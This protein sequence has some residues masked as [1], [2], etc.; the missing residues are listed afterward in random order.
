MINIEIKIAIEKKIANKGSTRSTV[1]CFAKE[2]RYIKLRIL[3]NLESIK[4]IKISSL[5]A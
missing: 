4:Y 2:Y 3:K 1:S 5:N